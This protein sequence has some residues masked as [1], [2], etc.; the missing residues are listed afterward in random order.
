MVGCMWLRNQVWFEAFNKCCMDHNFASG[1]FN[2]KIININVRGLCHSVT[3]YF[4][5]KQ[6]NMSMS[7]CTLLCKYYDY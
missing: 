6:N 2:N 5:H 1:H 4:S 7:D 3:L